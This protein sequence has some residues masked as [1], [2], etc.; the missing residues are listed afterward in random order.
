MAEAVGQTCRL[1]SVVLDCGDAVALAQFYGQL[2]DCPVDVGDPDW[3]EVHLD[4]TDLKL[5]FQRVAG[6]RAPE[7]PDGLPQQIH[8][9]ITVSDLEG[10]SARAVA[11]GAR[12][13]GPPVEDG[14]SRNIG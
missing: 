11:L 13:L 8:L 7:W 2:F 14:D 4:G 10:A 6:H 1:R 9:D 12:V 5:A 3:C